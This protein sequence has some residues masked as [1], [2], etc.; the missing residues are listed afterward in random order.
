MRPLGLLAQLAGI[1]LAIFLLV[2]FGSFVGTRNAV[3]RQV[4]DQQVYDMRTWLNATQGTLQ[5]FFVL[6]RLEGVRESISAMGSDLD[7]DVALLVDAA[8]RVV[9]STQVADEG[10]LLSELAYEL[11]PNVVERVTRTRTTDVSVG[12]RRSALHGYVSVCDPNMYGGLRAPRCGFL[13]KRVNLGYHQANAV[14]FLYQQATTT[15]LGFGGCSLLLLVI[16][17]RAVARRVNH[18]VDVLG[19]FGRGERDARVCLA[20]NDELSTISRSVDQILQELSDDEVALRASEQFKQAMID[21]ANSAIISTDAQGTIRFFSAGAERMLGYR[22]DELVGVANGEILHDPEDV[23]RRL[24]DDAAS[25]GLAQRPRVGLRKLMERSQ[26]GAYEDEWT[27]VRR[28]GSKLPVSLSV[29]ALLDASGAVEGYLAVARDV[30]QDRDVAQRLKL[31]KN[32]FESAGEAILVTDARLRIVDVNPAYLDMTGFSRAEVIGSKPR[33]SASGRHD[34]SFYRSIWRAVRRDGYWSGELWD[35]RK[36]GELFPQSLTISAIKDDQGRIS[37]YVGIF[38]DV[39][40]QKAAEEELERMAYFDPLTGLPNRALFKDRLQHEMDVATRKQGRVAL[41]FIDL[42]RFKFVNDTLGHEAGDKLLLEAA[43][44][45]KQV[46]RQSDTLARLGGD[47]FTLVVADA[48]DMTDVGHVA[49]KMIETL[50]KVFVIDGREVFIGASVGIA[51]YPDDGRSVSSL[52][53]NADTAMYLA[54]QA[55]RG[56]Y[57]FFKRE[58][59]TQNERRLA[60]EASLRRAVDNE[61][62]VLHYQPKIDLA[63]RAVVGFEALLRWQH[64]DFGLIAPGDFIPL[65]EETGLILP[66]SRWVLRAALAQL[67]DWHRLGYV[68]LDMAVNLSARQF[69]DQQLVDD[70]TSVLRDTDIE[71]GSLELELTESLLMVDAAR[72]LAIMRRL[73]DLGVKLSIDDFGVGYSSLSY[74]KRFPIHSLKIDR[75]FVRDVVDNPEDAAIVSAIMSL[76]ATLQLQVVAEGV[77]TT[78]Q[79]AFLAERGCDLVQGYLYSRPLPVAEASEFLAAWKAP[80]AIVPVASRAG[81][82]RPPAR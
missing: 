30:S 34:R 12:P 3:L 19:R 37:N 28:D 67:A 5:Q 25:G 56:T 45:I 72:A 17:H 52:T 20:G 11:D 46:V 24:G 81:P 49:S 33:A 35:R 7:L 32:V 43:W 2:S 41:L 1:A 62:F 74:L 54:K 4:T 60:L 36:N 80:R 27:Y 8:G 9:A 23:Q 77:E 6:G 14:E 73:R 39:T 71:A 26:Q 15:V 31:A 29:T 16:F 18:I 75:G 58:M 57:R 63:R 66:M 51:V 65:A 47:E 59:N 42:D 53:K 13:Y 69:Q 82:G 44:R 38:K 64:P 61:E 78:A 22:A 79:E 10:H 68:D 21:S 40:S 70:V 50:E 76:A 48:H 55:G